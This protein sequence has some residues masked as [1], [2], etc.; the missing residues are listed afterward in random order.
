MHVVPGSQKL[1]ALAHDDSASIAPA[2]WAPCEGKGVPIPMNPGDVLL[3][4]DHLVVAHP[5]NTCVLSFT[6]TFTGGGYG[7]L[8]ND[9]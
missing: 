2:A 6:F 1:G 9:H 8:N 3:Y 4:V 5:P 7:N